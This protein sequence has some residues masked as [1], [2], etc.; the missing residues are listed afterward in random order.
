MR[1]ARWLPEREVDLVYLYADHTID[2]RDPTPA[3]TDFFTVTRM[4]PW[5]VSTWFMCTLETAGKLAAMDFEN[6]DIQETTI[7][8]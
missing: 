3:E 2:A 1:R 8:G 5:G 6:L 7:V 4:D